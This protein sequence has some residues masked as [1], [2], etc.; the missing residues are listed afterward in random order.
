M[1]TPL[2]R[3]VSVQTMYRESEAQ[4]DPYSAEYIIDPDQ[5]E[6]EVGPTRSV[7]SCPV[8]S[9]PARLAILARRRNL[10]TSLFG[11]RPDPCT[12]TSQIRRGSAGEH[13]RD[14]D[15]PAASR[16]EGWYICPDALLSQGG[17]PPFT[18]V[19]SP[20][21]L[22]LLMLACPYLLVRLLCRTSRPICLP[23]RTRPPLSFAN[24][25]LRSAR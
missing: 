6:P 17:G 7:S 25:C 11:A 13:A 18:R 16:Q 9:C 3:D 23:S 8:L 22:R 21:C 12:G 4:T 5:E 10:F 19:P 24:G 15:D 20:A 1:E 2:T 14:R